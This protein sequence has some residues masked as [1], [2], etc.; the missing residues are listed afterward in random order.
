MKRKL[1][2]IVSSIIAVSGCSESG[3][4]LT[5]FSTSNIPNNSNYVKADPTAGISNSERFNDYGVHDPSVIK[6]DGTYYIFGSHLAAAKSTDLMNWQEVSS[7]TEG[8][9]DTSPLFQTYSTEIAEGIA[10]TDNFSG[11]WAANVIQAPNGKFWFYYNHCGQA[12]PEEPNIGTE[13]CYHRSYLGLAEADSIEGPYVNK[14]IFYARVT[15]TVNWRRTLWM[16]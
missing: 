4:D 15:A 9:V 3:K 6:V 16:V 10:W 1:A 12:K 8:N 2:L 7:L 14:G 11:N 5:D 13:V